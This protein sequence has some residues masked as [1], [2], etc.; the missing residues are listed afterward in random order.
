MGPQEALQASV[1]NRG[2]GGGGEIPSSRIASGGSYPPA[3]EDQEMK[4]PQTASSLY[5]PLTGH[6]LGFAAAPC[7]S[8][9]RGETPRPKTPPEARPTARERQ[10]QPHRGKAV[11]PMRTRTSGPAI[12][13][14]IS[15]RKGHRLFAVRRSC[16][17]TVAAL[18][19]VEPRATK[20]GSVRARVASFS[21][22]TKRGSSPT[23]VGSRPRTRSRFVG[24]RPRSSPS[25]SVL[26]HEHPLTSA[27]R[28]EA[29][30]ARA[31]AH[32]T[33]RVRPWP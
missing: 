22:P 18:R 29:L 13:L 25:F 9:E 30:A 19:T 11:R 32:R 2:G 16:P 1:L 3:P 33:A 12:G 17:D 21:I 24:M 7:F 31:Y 28:N 10:P 23:R 26:Q 8:V 27:P 20:P 14:R 4:L 5:E 15:S 6:L